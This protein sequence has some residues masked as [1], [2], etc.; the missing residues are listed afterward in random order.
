MLRQLIVN[1]DD[2]G[3]SPGVSRGIITAH[4]QGIVTST[5]ILITAPHA[6]ESIALARTAA[7]KL[8]LGLHLNLTSGQPA[9]PPAQIQDLVAADGSFLHKSALGARLPTL[10]PDQVERELRAQVALFE[11]LAGRPPD[12]LDSHHH[13]TYLSPAIFRIMLMIARE[14][15]VP[16]RNPLPGT[17]E[18]DRRAA[19]FMRDV[20][21]EHL[22]DSFTFEL[23]NVLRSMRDGSGVR[24]PQT[25]IADFYGPRAIL[26]DLLLLLL[27]MPEGTAEL[28][29]H[30]AAV[31]DLLRQG[32]GYADKRADELAAL[33]HPS[34][35][36]LIHSEFIQLITFADLS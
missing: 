21:G 11:Q 4:T 9:L 13:I 31:D 15:G 22:S 18:Q 28:M 33:T 17:T 29:C 23:A 5:S 36:E 8:G 2:F 1:A 30:P 27:D 35:R 25:F 7:P 19:V 3:Y 16:I 20:L 26:G 6:A 34:A 14:L 12:H 24:M 10:N 32:S